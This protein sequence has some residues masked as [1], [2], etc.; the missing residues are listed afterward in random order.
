MSLAWAEKLETGVGGAAFG[1]TCTGFGATHLQGM[2]QDAN[3]VELLY[4]G[5][6]LDRFPVPP[7][8]RTASDTFR[9]LSVGRLVEKKGFDRL[10]EAFAL[11]PEN[12][13]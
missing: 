5:L 3:R 1:V 13:N 8:S 11:L 6:D 7:A 10:I 12:M 4:H 9:I 2:A